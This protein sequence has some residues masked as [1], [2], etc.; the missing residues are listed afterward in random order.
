MAI[1][2]KTFEQTM[3]TRSLIDGAL[4]MMLYPVVMPIA[5]FLG[6]LLNIHAQDTRLLARKAPASPRTTD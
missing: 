3:R 2:T 1:H 5:A 6:P 4:V